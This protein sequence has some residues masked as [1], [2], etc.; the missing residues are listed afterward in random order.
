MKAQ[1]R[2]RRKYI[3]AF[4]IPFVVCFALGL[5]LAAFNS[6]HSRQ[7]HEQ[8]WERQ[9]VEDC[10]SG[11]L[12][13]AACQCVFHELRKKHSVSELNQWRLVGSP[14]QIDQSADEAAE[15]CGLEVQ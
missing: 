2:S 13:Q 10:S 5:L 4:G 6:Q 8:E 9:F 11:H 14:A 12:P 15:A 7:N 3:L 1:S